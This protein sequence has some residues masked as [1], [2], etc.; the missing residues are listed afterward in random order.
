LAPDRVD[1]IS[2]LDDG[3]TQDFAADVVVVIG[4]VGVQVD[5]AKSFDDC[6]NCCVD[7]DENFHRAVANFIKLFS[8]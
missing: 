7:G 2:L 3:R 1:P 6:E 8:A 5:V 4:N